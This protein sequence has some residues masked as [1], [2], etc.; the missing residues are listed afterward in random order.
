MV[1]TE[2]VDGFANQVSAEVVAA[3][4]ARYPLGYGLPEDVASTVVFYLSP[5][6]RWITGTNLIMDGGLT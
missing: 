5:A 4:E 3:D 1:K 2:V 6:S